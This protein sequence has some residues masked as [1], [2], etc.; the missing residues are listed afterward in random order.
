MFNFKQ[1]KLVK[2]CDSDSHSSFVGIRRAADGDL[3]FRLPQGFDHFPE[4]DFEQTKRLFFKM[5]RTFKKFERDNTRDSTDKTPKGKDN[6]KR[7]N[8]AYRFKDAE[9]N[10]VILYSKIDLI[11]NILTAYHELALNTLERRVGQDERVDYAKLE[12]YLHRAVYLPND[13]IYIDEMDLPRQTLQYESVTL[14]HLFCFIVA[15]LYTEMELT[16]KVRVKEL[17]AYFIQQ[18]LKHEQSLFKE[19]VFL[20]TI[21]QL[22]TVLHEIDKYTVYKDDD[23]WRLYEAIE[24]FLY[25][26]LDMET[27]DENG[28]YWGIS[29]FSAVWEDM[30]ATW[31]FATQPH[32]IIYADTNIMFNRKRVANA[33][34]A[35]YFPIYKKENFNDPFFIEFR[36][37]KRWMRPDL[38]LS[39]S[40]DIFQIYDWKYMKGDCFTSYNKKVQRDVT[41]Q[42]CYGLPL[43]KLALKSGL[44]YGE[45][46]IALNFFI[47]W[48]YVEYEENYHYIG[49]YMEDDVHPTIQII[50]GNFSLIQAIYLSHD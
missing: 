27:P 40:Y 7:Q 3:E 1:L 4:Q 24:L 46:I 2:R 49:D 29:N 22:K 11:E 18:Q 38:V 9:D 13:V 8:H 28:V 41:K 30:C 20:D 25:G 33:K 5:Y 14:I 15:E 45:F 35:G 31:A 48:F 23:Y 43:E 32:I 19:A 42:L 47:P 34:S 36:G 44:S 16:T 6:A 39:G 21:H 50:K 10:D 17:A 26:E 12:Q 37:Q